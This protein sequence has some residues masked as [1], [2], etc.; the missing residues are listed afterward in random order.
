M[1]PTLNNRISVLVWT[2]IFFRSQLLPEGPHSNGIE[3]AN[4]RPRIFFACGKWGTVVTYYYCI[5]LESLESTEVAMKYGN[6][7]SLGKPADV[8]PKSSNAAIKNKINEDKDKN[9]ISARWRAGN[10]M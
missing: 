1:S 7:Q 2:Q 5:L 4:F 6:Q 8:N 9:K 3:F 10:W